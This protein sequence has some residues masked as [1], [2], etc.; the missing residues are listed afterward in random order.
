[1]IGCLVARP[2]EE[3][4]HRPDGAGSSEI[5]S[6]DTGSRDLALV[7]GSGGND[8]P[9][10]LGLPLVGVFG[11][12]RADQVVLANWLLDLQVALGQVPPERA[13]GASEVVVSAAVDRHGE[14]G[15][16]YGQRPGAPSGR[17]P[18]RDREEDDDLAV[19][20][21]EDLLCV[22]CAAVARWPKA[23]RGERA[24]QLVKRRGPA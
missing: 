20:L 12:A 3:Q 5:S 15:R 6:I 4:A 11:V 13:V 1:M 21:F 2:A 19:R 17:D 18:L 23:L 14:L 9:G 16:G 7:E 10:D 24:G 22:E 8:W